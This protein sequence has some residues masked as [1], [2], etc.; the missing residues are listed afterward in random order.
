MINLSSKLLKTLY[1]GEN[2]FKINFK[3][4]I[5]IL[6]I[7]IGLLA[8]AIAIAII[9]IELCRASKREEGFKEARKS[10]EEYK[11]FEE[12]NKDE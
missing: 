7:I 9:D 10:V 6:E 11:A 8:A 12:D 3:E 1:E 5:K 2:V 4:V